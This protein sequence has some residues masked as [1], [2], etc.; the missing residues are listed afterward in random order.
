MDNKYIIPIAALA[1]L[2][3]GAANK[4]DDKTPIDEIPK[5]D[6]AP[7][8]DTDRTPA[9]G[10]GGLTIAGAARL[11]NVERVDYRRM[12]ATR[13][14]ELLYDYGMAAAIDILWSEWVSNDNPFVFLFPNKQALFLNI[15]T[16]IPDRGRDMYE[17]RALGAGPNR[18]I[19]WNDA[20]IYEDI[21]CLFSCSSDY[22]NCAEWKAWHVAL[23]NHYGST[24]K[25]NNIWLAA[26][27]S[28]LNQCMFLATVMC[29]DTDT[30][31]YDCDFVEY[32][33]SKGITIGNVVSNGYCDVSQVVM[34]IVEGV[35]DLSGAAADVASGIKTTTGALSVIAPVVI[36]GGGLLWAYRQSSKV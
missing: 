5:P 25:A 11:L 2:A 1:L 23:E 4:K 13:W 14:H 33:Y 10:G 20:P 36:V 21:Y 16:Y 30:C 29:P 17:V 18:P 6:E 7:I 3:F 12:W 26:W 32:F 34:N 22:W 9:G 8:D 15:S 31:R 19:A 24:S 35:K 28:E 27:Q